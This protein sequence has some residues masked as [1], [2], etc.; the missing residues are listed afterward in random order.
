MYFIALWA[1]DDDRYLGGAFS[2]GFTLL[3][4]LGMVGISAIL[5]ILVVYAWAIVWLVKQ[6]E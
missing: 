2:G 6:G 4:V 1:V 5:T 3:V